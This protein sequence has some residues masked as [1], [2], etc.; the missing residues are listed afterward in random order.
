MPRTARASRANWCYHVL[1]R[2]NGQS[3]MFHSDEDYAAFVR[4]FRSGLPAATDAYS[5]LLPDAEPFSSGPLAAGR[6]RLG[7][8]DAVAAHE[9]RAALPSALRRQGPRMAGAIQGLPDPARRTFIEC[10]A[11]CR[12][13]RIAGKPGAAC[14]GM[15]VVKYR[16]RGRSENCD[17]LSP[18]PVALPR[19]WVE[20]VNRPQSE[21]ELKALG[22]ASREGTPF[23]GKLIRSRSS[24]WDCSPQSAPRGRPRVQRE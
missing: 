22:K 10:V 21:A 16:H 17:W 3:R 15:A 20:L 9:S 4:L 11:V 12:A 24:G 18:P 14:P 19:D 1:N 13:E 8:L 6:W 23:G 5:R 7:T 2:G